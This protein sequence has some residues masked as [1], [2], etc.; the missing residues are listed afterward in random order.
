M[1]H[2]AFDEHVEEVVAGLLRVILYTQMAQVIVGD[3]ESGQVTD[4][5]PLIVQTTA[6]R[7][8]DQIEELFRLRRRQQTGIWET[9]QTTHALWF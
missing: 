2:L 4:A 7:V 5:H 6:L 9:A 8:G 3:S 1:P